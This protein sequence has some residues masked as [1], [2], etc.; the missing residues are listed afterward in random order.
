M[1][2][3]GVMKERAFIIAEYDPLHNGHIYHMEAT[4][5]AGAEEIVVIMSPDFVQRGEIAAFDKGLRAKA[6]VLSGAD[7]VVENPLK[8][9]VSGAKYFA[10]GGMR[11][12]QRLGLP[13]VLSFGCSAEEDVLRYLS[14]P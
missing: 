11:T 14:L 8:F 6:A 7:L 1:K 10:Y 13:G 2:E 4:R 9:V 12:I 3:V 5:T